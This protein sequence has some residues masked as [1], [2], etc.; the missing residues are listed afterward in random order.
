MVVVVYV[1]RTWPSFEFQ[2]ALILTPALHGI[3]LPPLQWH[4]RLMI[5]WKRCDINGSQANFAAMRR[6]SARM[7]SIV[8]SR[9]HIVAVGRLISF[10]EINR[11]VC[12]DISA[13]M[14]LIGSSKGEVLGFSNSESFPRIFAMVIVCVNDNCIRCIWP[15]EA[16]WCLVLVPVSI[17]AI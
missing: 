9:S 12:L 14:R 2:L 15:L 8:L 17:C 5:C 10:I 13:D 4:S 3:W 11:S 1:T 16:L 7:S 6:T